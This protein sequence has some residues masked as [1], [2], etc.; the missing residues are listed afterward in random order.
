MMVDANEDCWVL[1]FPPMR[2]KAE[3][4]ALKSPASPSLYSGIIGEVLQSPMKDDR[5]LFY[6]YF[7]LLFVC[8]MK[9]PRWAVLSAFACSARAVQAEI[10]RGYG[11]RVIREDGRPVPGATVS[12][13]DLVLRS[14]L[15]Y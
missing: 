9:C 15:K 4:Q 8:S 2:A 3:K 6:E 1:E 5:H 11:G 12:V 14:L 7:N 10:T 13:N